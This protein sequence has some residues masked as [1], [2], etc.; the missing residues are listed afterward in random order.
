MQLQQIVSYLCKNRIPVHFDVLSIER[1][2]RI[3]RAFASIK[4]PAPIR[5]IGQQHPGCLSQGAAQVGNGGIN[6]DH[7]I[8][9]VTESRCI[10]EVIDLVAEKSNGR[11]TQRCS[12]NFTQLRLQAHVLILAGQMW[13]RGGEIHAAIAVVLLSVVTVPDQANARL[14]PFSQS[15]SPE[16]NLVSAGLQVS[17][18][19]GD[20][21]ERR[22]ESQR[23]R[24][25]WAMIVEGRQCASLLYKTADAS[26]SLK[27]SNERLANLKNDVC[28]FVGDQLCITAKLNRVPKSLLAMQQY[29]LVLQR[30]LPKPKGLHEFALVSSRF[31]GPPS[32][33]VNFLVLRKASTEKRCQSFI[34][35]G[36]GIIGLESDGFVEAGGRG[37][38]LCELME[39]KAAIAV[40]FGIIELE[41][42]SIV[43]AR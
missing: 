13:K 24:Q 1:Y 17:A 33:F 20:R 7:H 42:D 4:Q 3:P 23:Q 38:Q 25:Q 27:Q 5:R 41:S 14:G 22:F 10:C 21:V 43:V 12:I 19:I 35:K 30:T 8:H 26:K 37:I 34:P 11:G 29:R 32:P 6:T 39:R 36:F 28:A 2:G 16:F 18:R 15:P 40:S 31:F 9:Q